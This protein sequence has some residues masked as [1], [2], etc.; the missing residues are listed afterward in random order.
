[1]LKSLFILFIFVLGSP[2]IDNIRE[3]YK[4][5][6]ASKTKSEAFYKELKNV[7]NSDDAVLVGYK[8]ASIVLKARFI[9]GVKE[10]KSLF[11]EGVTLLE[12]KIKS[13]PKNIELRLIRLSIQ[14][15]TPKILKYKKNISEDKS[16]IKR[17][18]SYIKNKKKLTYFKNFVSQSKSFTNQEKSVILKL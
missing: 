10:K 13:N 8:S 15:N 18:I 16:F 9:K 2:S 5:A 4:D 17:N 12:S 11:K 14:E 6:S 7:K 1:M 3:L